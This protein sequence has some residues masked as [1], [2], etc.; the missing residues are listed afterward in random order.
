MNA[1]LFL[2]PR[3]FPL[4]FASSPFPRRREPA[5]TPCPPR[6][7]PAK[8]PHFELLKDRLI[9]EADRG[10]LRDALSTLDLMA[11]LRAPADLVAY[12]VLLKACI[13][14]RDIAHGRAVHRRLDESGLEPDSVAFNSLIT[15]YSKCGDWETAGAIFRGMGERRDLV[16]WSTMI[17]SAANAGVWSRAV[18]LFV[19]MLEEGIRPNEFCFSSVLRAC[20]NSEY[21][22]FGLMVFGFL[23][24][25][26]YF[27]PDVCVGCALIDL[28]ARNRELALARKVFDEMFE[29]NAVAWTL[30]ITR[31]TQYSLVKDAIDLF[32]EME[33]EGF[34]PDQFALS[35]VISASTELG[36]FQLGQ[37]LHSRVIRSGL[38]ED[39]CVG[40]SLVNMYAKA[41]TE[42]SMEDS[43][44]VFDRMVEHNVMSWTAFIS[45]LAQRRH[46]KEAIDYF[47]QMIQGGVRPNHITFSSILK[48]CAN[49]PDPAAG[50]QVYGLVV[51]YGMAS[52]NCVGNSMISM[53]A[54]S[55]RME[56][57]RKAFE[58]LLDKNLI[59]YNAA[60][61][62]NVK[63]SDS[64]EDFAPNHETDYSEIGAS[65]FTFASLLSGAATIGA[66]SRG[67]QL[68][69]WLLKSGFYSDQSVNNALI[70]MYS[71]CGDIDDACRVFDEMICRNVVSWTSMIVALAKHGYADRAL[72][73]FHEMTCQGTKPNEVTYI[74]VLSA[75]SHAGLVEEGHKHFRS[76]SSEHGIVP[77]MEHHACMV[78]L[79]GRLGFLQEAIDFIYAM[80]FKASALV[81]RAL[82]GACRIHGDM[83]LGEKAAKHILELE[84]HDPAAYV[85][86]SNIYAATGQ[87]QNVAGIRS[88]MKEKQLVKEA[89]LS[90][91]EIDNSIHEFHVG[92]TRHSRSQ[93]IYAKLDELVIEIKRMGYVPDLNFVLHD[94]EDE[95]K[96]QFL[97]Q[98]SEKIAVAFGLISTS[99]PRPIRVFKNL[100]ICGD[101]HTAIKFIS[102]ATGRKIILRD[103]NR[104]HCVEDGVCSCGEYW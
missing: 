18:A 6:A 10:R 84:P 51:K 72:S 50:E 54:K 57:A 64:G 5:G 74:A 38:T 3:S 60:V 4:P 95:L 48:A 82:L 100:R 16:S 29:R 41:S 35:S 33:Q 21:F 32:L 96:E 19:A 42:G 87:W 7:A 47:H 46:D 17:S 52:I 71:R 25:M 31:Y 103:S 73:M 55:D 27:G 78:D 8:H 76:M 79:L 11:E 58:G 53:Y 30:M 43:R 9:R 12:T 90:W 70:S 81:W 102:K 26:G 77:R 97:F 61:D 91:M 49:I 99:A 40:C 28:F 65:A 15:L 56:E 14:S 24:K 2:P 59:S 85:L 101:C 68:H 75:C 23:M 89:G 44:K 98:H 86:L 39:V 63:N 22:Y 13:R 80:P 1:C 20:S 88:S 92:D 94:V 83:V 34:R 62:G 69:A 45:G 66:V 36:S 93:E 37:Q 67:H 104:F